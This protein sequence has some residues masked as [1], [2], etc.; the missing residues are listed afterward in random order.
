MIL[1]APTGTLA[2]VARHRW[3]VTTPAGAVFGLLALVVWLFGVVAPVLADEAPGTRLGLYVFW[4]EGCPHCEEQKPFLAELAARHPGLVVH[5]HEI[6]LSDA[7][8]ALFR[9]LARMHGIE[10][11]AVPTVFVGGRAF[12]GDAPEIRRAIEAT[13]EAALARAPPPPVGPA[14]TLDLPILGSLDLAAQPLLVTTLAVALFDGFNPCSLWVLSLL[15]GLVIRSGSRGRIALVGL[16][17]LATTAVIYGGFIAGLFG[18]LGLILHLGWVRW[19]VGGLALG[20]GTIDVK[21]YF[22]FKSG[23]SLTIA[24]RHKPGLYERMRG[25]LDPTRSPA[26]L[27]LATIVMASG[28]AFVELPCTAG[29]PVVWNGIMLEEGVTGIGYAAL[30]AVYITVYLLDELIFFAIAV[31]TLQL[32]RFGEGNVRLLK[33][34]GGTIMIALGLVMLFRPA[35]MSDIGM[36]LLVFMAAIATAGLVALSHRWWQGDGSRARSAGR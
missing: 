12:I 11:G 2:A 6:W 17:F 29:F 26:T 32:Q 5:S 10:A 31:T 14:E 20:I 30:L 35:L 24:E 1:P 4:G 28:A 22:L 27:M 34:L 23:P 18:I 21:D 33:L 19:L 25:L 9:T 36:T 7:D 15:L 8:H 16:T 13:V 3:D